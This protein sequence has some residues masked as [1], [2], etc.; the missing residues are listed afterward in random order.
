[1]DPN[2]PERV[3]FVSRAIKWSSGGSGKLGHPKLHQLLALTLWKGKTRVTINYQLKEQ[4]AALRMGNPHYFCLFAFRAKLQ[5]ITLSFSALIWWRGLCTDVG[6]VFI[7]TRVSRRGGH[8]CSAGRLTVSSGVWKFYYHLFTTMQFHTG[9][10][11]F[12]AKYISRNLRKECVGHSA[13]QCTEVN[14]D[15]TCLATNWKKKVYIHPCTIFQSCF[16]LF[17]YVQIWHLMFWV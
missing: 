15:W 9:L 7:S 14:R 11:I 12:S 3:A 10:T 16:L 5:W 13:I 4:S 6:G 2:S 8:V 1:M 17:T